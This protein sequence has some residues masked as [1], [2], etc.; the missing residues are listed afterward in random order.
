MCIAAPGT[1]VSVTPDGVTI[2]LA[3]RR[4]QALAPEPGLRLAPGD[5]VVVNAG[6]IVRRV[7]REQAEAM[8]RALRIVTGA[9]GPAPGEGSGEG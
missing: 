8:E 6:I 1:V 2:D 3:G 5:R 7:D 9:D 4:L